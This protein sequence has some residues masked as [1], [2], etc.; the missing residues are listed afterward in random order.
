VGGVIPKVTMK[1]SARDSRSFMGRRGYFKRD[2]ADLFYMEFWGAF[3]RDL[4]RYE[5][6]AADG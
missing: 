2:S 4:E 1:A 3:G 5:G 6:N